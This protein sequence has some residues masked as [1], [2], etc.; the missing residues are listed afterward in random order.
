MYRYI[1]YTLSLRSPRLKKT[2]ACMKKSFDLSEIFG[3]NQA[4]NGPKSNS[5]RQRQ[6]KL[7]KNASGDVSEHTFRLAGPFLVDFVVPAGSRKS[8]KSRFFT[9]AH[10]LRSATFR[11]MLA[12][13]IDRN[14]SKN[15]SKMDRI[16]R[17]V[18]RQCAC[19]MQ[20]Y[21]AKNQA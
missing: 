12:S 15:R 3:E 5:E 2:G 20:E 7:I 13:K 1:N 9:R 11:S 21:F 14:S 4:K 10:G 18:C 16:M 8:L 17:L 19:K 6:E